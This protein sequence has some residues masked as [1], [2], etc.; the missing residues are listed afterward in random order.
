MRTKEPVWTFH[1]QI[2]KPVGTAM[3]CRRGGAGDC[4][5]CD[6]FMTQH[7]SQ[8]QQHTLVH[9]LCMTQNRP[10]ALD[11]IFSL[12]RGPLQ[13]MCVCVDFKRGAHVQVS[14]SI[15][16]LSTPT[17]KVPTESSLG[18]LDSLDVT[19]PH[20]CTPASQPNSGSISV[21][22]RLIRCVVPM[23]CMPPFTNLFD[24]ATNNCEC[25]CWC[26]AERLGICLSLGACLCSRSRQTGENPPTEIARLVTKEYIVGHRLHFF[27]PDR[28]KLVQH[29]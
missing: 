7:L 10:K 13:R 9:T 1:C 18:I 21:N 11:R 24:A 12:S 29:D 17:C 3:A 14:R 6:S 5:R 22:Q 26:S 15:A 20:A 2:T 4:G 25:V 23:R 27:C 16:Q 28:E 8:Q 19:P